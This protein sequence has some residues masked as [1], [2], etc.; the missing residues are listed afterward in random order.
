MGLSVYVICESDINVKGIC[1]ISYLITVFKITGF[2]ESVFDLS[3]IFLTR[4]H[5]TQGKARVRVQ[6]GKGE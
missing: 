2:S 4:F 1:G 6:A 5:G 3:L